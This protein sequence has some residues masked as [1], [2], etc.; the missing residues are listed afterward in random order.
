MTTIQIQLPDSSD[1]VN[2]HG[3]EPTPA[4]GQNRQ[5]ILAKISAAAFNAFP[6]AILPFFKK[7]FPALRKFFRVMLCVVGQI[8]LVGI[9]AGRA[10]YCPP[11]GF[12]PG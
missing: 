7:L 6:L 9:V 5:F 1:L 2:H 4:I 3:L 10:A 11:Q 8:T 12:K